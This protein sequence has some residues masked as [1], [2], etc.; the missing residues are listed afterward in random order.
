MINIT[1]N[2]SGII[3]PVKVQ[4]NASKER[5]IGE[6]NGQLKIAVTAAPEKGKANKAIIK[7]LAEK[8][9]TKIS[10]IRVISGETSREKKLFIE[11]AKASNVIARLT[12]EIASLR[13]Q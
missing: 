2:D 5:I 9:G 6:Y 10:S 13:S 7:L 4:P 3:I 1:E 8:F 11:G 12:K